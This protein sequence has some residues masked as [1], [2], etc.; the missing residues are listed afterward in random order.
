[1]TGAE[2]SLLRLGGGLLDGSLDV[3][4]GPFLAGAPRAGVGMAR[5]ATT[6]ALDRIN[7]RVLLA[8]MVVDPSWVV[9][10]AEF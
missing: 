1:L 8:T 6:S 9:A 4:A 3:G 10:S 7:R 5:A 2:G